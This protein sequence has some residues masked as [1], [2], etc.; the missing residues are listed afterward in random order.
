MLK[1]MP[2]ALIFCVRT[3][4]CQ[5]TTISEIPKSKNFKFELVGNP[6]DMVSGQSSHLNHIMAIFYTN[7]IYAIFKKT[8][9][10]VKFSE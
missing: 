1:D 3:F 4:N 10:K 7:L 5:D 2:E 6:E 8:K 9:G